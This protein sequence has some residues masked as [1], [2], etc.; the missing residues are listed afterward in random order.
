MI[1][2]Y[3]QKGKTLALDEQERVCKDSMVLAPRVIVLLS[4]HLWATL[5]GPNEL[6]RFCLYPAL[7]VLDNALLAVPTRTCHRLLRAILQPNAP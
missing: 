3:Q 6:Q 1:R 7:P 5:A 2:P 4:D